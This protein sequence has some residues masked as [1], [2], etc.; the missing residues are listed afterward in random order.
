MSEQFSQP[1][2]LGL[3]DVTAADIQ[4][5]IDTALSMKEI[6]NRPVKKVPTLRGITICNLFFEPSTRTRISFELAEKRLSADVINFSSSMSS[7]TKG[8][9]MIDT[10]KNIQAMAVDMFV[11]RHGCPGAAH[12][13]SQ[14]VNGPV[15]NA[16][17]GAHEHPTQAL[18]DMTS[19]QEKLGR[20]KG[21]RVTIIG[22][23]L[24]S[25]V[26]RSNIYGLLKMGAT[27]NL[28][29]PA[30]LV[31]KG[32]AKLGVNIYHDLDEALK[33]SDV[34]NILRIQ[35]ERQNKSLFPSIREYAMLYGVT[36]ERLAKVDHDILVMHPGPINRGVEIEP[37][38]ADGPH[39][40]ILD[41]VTNGVATRMAILYLLSGG[42]KNES[43]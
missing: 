17:D 33:N 12:F 29:G 35:L 11:M 4:M 32:F 6:F 41:Q 37:E 3:K 2:L 15:V 26:A 20:I 30:P 10:V 9:T 39:S 31:P 1:H 36:R 42:I 38:V 13:L 18:L 7:L 16:G 8:E 25:R 19:I 23:I 21:L 27:V 40:V 24:N 34:I 14:H 28:C 22:D 5:V 43:N